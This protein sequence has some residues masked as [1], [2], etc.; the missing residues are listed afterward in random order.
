MRIDRQT[1]FTLARIIDHDQVQSLL[2]NASA[3]GETRDLFARPLSLALASDGHIMVLDAASGALIAIDDRPSAEASPSQL[4]SPQCV[5]TDA[6]GNCYVT[7][8]DNHRVAIFD[9]RL[10]LL[11][12]LPEPPFSALGLPLG[13]LN[14]IAFAPLGEYYI[15]DESNGRV[16]RYD[17]T[18]RFDSA[19]GD[20][21]DPWGRLIHPRGL[22]VAP[23]DGALYVAD[24]GVG[25]VVVF[26]ANGTPRTLMGAGQITD[27]WSVA[28]NAHDQCVVTDRARG[29]IIVFTRDGSIEFSLEGADFQTKAL[30]GPT[31]VLLSD[32]SL[33]VC[34]PPTA[35]ILEVRLRS[36]VDK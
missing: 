35:R 22:A 12:W 36:A 19:L 4:P 32:S 17:A 13:R 2:R 27:P 3:T 23:S 34:D 33:W 29:R 26:D 25:A 15:A 8:A 24:A 20:S 14:G 11:D 5:R 6:I 18:G 28:V 16:Y 31:D 7:D 9:H 30:E 21:G 1:T 10:R